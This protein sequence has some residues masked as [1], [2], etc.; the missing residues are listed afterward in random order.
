MNIDVKI[1]IKILANQIYQYTEWIIH[2]DEMEFIPGMHGWLNIQC[3][4]PYHQSK[5]NNNNYMITSLDAKKTF[6]K[7]QYLLMIKYLTN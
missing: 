1:F 7:I 2:N 3:N 6:Y 5:K 4:S